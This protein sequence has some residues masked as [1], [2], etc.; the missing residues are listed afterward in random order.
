MKRI[1][2]AA[3]AA[4]LLGAPAAYAKHGHDNG[5]HKGHHKHKH[6]HHYEQSYHYRAPRYE[7]R[8]YVQ[9]RYD[10]RYEQGRYL[11]Q[12]YYYVGGRRQYTR[13][14]KTG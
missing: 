6:K 12:T 14:S 4:S 9:P 5:K 10:H 13:G 11:P 2:M 7:E 3:L 1:L 8:V